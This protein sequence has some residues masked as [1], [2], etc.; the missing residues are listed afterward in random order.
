MSN[1]VL[2]LRDLP[3]GQVLKNF[4]RRLASI[5]TK[6]TD[7]MLTTKFKLELPAGC[8]LREDAATFEECRR[9]Y[10]V[11]EGCG[12]GTLTGFLFTVIL[13]GFR[14]FPDG[15]TAEI[16]ANR[17]VYDEDEFRIALAGAVGAPLPR[18]TVKALIKRLQMEVRARGN[19][20]NRF[21][22]EVMMKEYRQTLC[23]KTLPKGVD[24]S[25][26]DRL[27]EEMARELTSRYRSWNE[28]KGDLLGACKA[29]DAALRGFG[30]FPSLATMVT[31]AAARRLPKDS[32]IVFDPQS[33]CIDVQT[34]GVDA[35]PYAAVSTI[36]SYPESVGEK[37]RDFVQNHLTTPSA[38]GLS[39]LFNRGLELFSEESVE[40]LCRLFHVP[41]D[42]RTRIVQ[43]Q[44]AARVTPRQSFFLKKG[45]APLGYHD[46]RSAFAG[47]IN[48]WTAN[49]LNRLEELQGL[50]HDLTDELRLPDLVRNGEDFLATTDCRR[51]E[52]EILCRSFSRERDRAQKAVEHLIGADP[53]QVVSDVAAI[54]EYSRIVN[55]LCAIKEQIVNSLRQAE[56]DKASRWTALWSEVKDEF[57]PWE[58][59]IRLP[60]LNGMSGG[61][62]PAQDELETIL[63]RYSDVG[64][65]ASEHFDAV[66]EWAAKTGAEGD[67]LKKFAET[68][69][70]RA[71]QR[72][73]GKYDGR[74]L[75][76]RLVL[77]RVARVVRD[78]SDACAENVRQWFL[79]EN[80]FAE[81][82]DFN[83]FFFNRLG[84]LYVSPFSNR[85]HAGYKLSDGL[86]ERS[87]AVWRELLALVKEMR[88]AYASFSEAGE[89]FLR[90]E[91]LLMGMRIGAL[92]KNIPAEVAALRLDDET[93]LE[94]VSEGLK[95]QLQQAEVPPSVLA[96]AFNVYVSLLSGCL[97]ALRR[98]RF[99]LRTKFSFVGNTALVYVPKEKSWPMPSRYE[100]SPSWTPI[101]E[102]DVLVRLS[103]GEV[104]VAETFRRAAALWGRT[105]DPVLKKALRELFHQLPH[106]WC[107]QVSVRSSGDMT[108]A[109]RKEDDRDVLIVEKKGK[110]DSTIISKKIAATALVRLVGPST[111]KERLNRLLLDVGE[112]ACDMT[113]L[114]DQEILQKVEDDRV[115]LSPG[116]LQFSLSVPISTP[117]EQCEDEV[118][119]ERK[120]THFRRIVAIDQGERGFAFAVF[121]LEDA[122]KKG[123]QPI[124]QG[125]VNIPSIRRLI[126]RV[127]SFRK[128]KQSVQKFSQRFD[129]TMFTLRENVAG[130]VCGSIAGL[131]CRYRA[132]PVLERQVSNL[133]SGGKQLELV[134]K[135]VNARFLDDRIPMHSLERTSWWCGTSDWVIPDL[136]VEVPESYA[137]KAKKDEILEKDGKFYRT[138]R[139][140]PG[141][142]VNAKWTS[143]ICSQCGGNAM[144]LIEK[145]RE[146]KVKTVTLD[147][148]GEVTLFGRTLRLYK[149]PS[150]ERSREARRR[151]ERAPW[152][153]PRADVRLSLDDFRRAVAEN[154]RRQPK[155]LQSRDT[156]QSR[157]FCVFT[158]CR[159]HNKE[160][161]ADINA[162]VNIGRRFLDSLLRE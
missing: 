12:N 105:T 138:L 70:Q 31:R 149:R 15:K 120:S 102:N 51:E 119:S 65:G 76:L 89:T 58:K 73:P 109:K 78:R 147:A 39:W 143:R 56:D 22:A 2:K 67:V 45:G 94:S 126:A 98:E 50:L 81:Q 136:W 10:G 40:E 142:G 49:Y 77:Q 29:V 155:S 133:A 24:E 121:R 38:A 43:I 161:H 8:P 131:M 150:E 106:D 9:L 37:R 141:A 20:D 75:A 139:I 101:F 68:E 18:F 60:K 152:T 26:V 14:I 59:L 35:M 111:H 34:I 44:N 162:A 17:S 128:S 95:L 52:V 21:V 125:F 123:A 23:G 118:K 27:F 103:T 108:P 156:S 47:R 159:C 114:A 7:A 42:Q 64:R 148:N 79:K 93:A 88:G 157:Y 82:K 80:I 84:N 92:T 112:V 134:Y 55:R 96:K 54:E 99:F 41:E 63:A 117:A 71:D 6:P 135:M 124:A 66:M 46:F 113:L 140:T 86:V 160:Q 13:S 11:V 74:E 19:K 25:Y 122:G 33:P 90:L 69:Q 3:S 57:Q 5:G 145:A 85:R 107:C 72:A 16:F 104:E 4:R 115:H 127:H 110:Y 153:E 158:D 36:L 91:S 116:E 154:M 83:K 146:E 53:L 97:I 62:P 100:A 130:D 87:G 132:I 137:V 28:L 61:V 30:D 129:S 151:N 32:T 48:S 144:E 1:Q